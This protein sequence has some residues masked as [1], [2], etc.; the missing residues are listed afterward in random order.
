MIGR[1]W[2]PLIGF[3][4]VIGILLSVGLVTLKILGPVPQFATIAGPTP[5]LPA[6][7]VAELQST[8]RP[9]DARRRI[10]IMLVGIGLSGAASQTANDLLPP[11][12]SF[13]VSPYSVSPD[14]LLTAMQQ[15]GREYLL[16][17]P[18]E[19]AAFP[20]N[21]AGPRALLTGAPVASNDANLAWALGR[22]SGEVGATGATDGLRG[23]RFESVSTLLNPVLAELSHRGLFYIDPRPNAAAPADIA[24]RSVDLVL[25]EPPDQATIDLHLQQLEQIARDKGAAL[26]LAGPPR[27]VLLHSLATWSTT[28]ERRG[29]VLVP[30]SR[31]VRG[32][33]AADVRPQ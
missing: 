23:E 25:D 1:T 26:G 21:D 3:W 20:V 8:A 17:L 4:A 13:A 6:D 30:V 7:A 12:I 24:G 28:L 29:L 33:L 14:N 19:P 10:A 2:R 18:L 32:N 27:P 15:R 22:M 9:A 5:T 31:L 16:S 11:A